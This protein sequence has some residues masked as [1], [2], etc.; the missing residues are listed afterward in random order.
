MCFSIQLMT[1]FVLPAT[2]LVLESNV[3]WGVIRNRGATLCKYP[4]LG[5]ICRSWVFT[6]V[7]GLHVRFVCSPLLWSTLMCD[8][9]QQCQ[10][11]AAVL[12]VPLKA[13]KTPH[14]S[15]ITSLKSCIL[16]SVLCDL[17]QWLFMPRDPACVCVR[18]CTVVSSRSGQIGPLLQDNTPISVLHTHLCLYFPAPLSF[19]KLWTQISMLLSS[20]TFCWAHYNLS[21]KLSS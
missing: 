20:A 12:P 6:H 10:S 18:P 8:T 5:R 7:S 19:F 16:L 21:W 9:D 1:C 3:C 11:P 15:H 2:I 14:I 13:R 4:R 17:T